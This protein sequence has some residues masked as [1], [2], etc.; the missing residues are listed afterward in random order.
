MELRVQGRTETREHFPKEKEPG[1]NLNEHQEFMSLQW[2]HGV[3]KEGNRC[4]GGR[5][6]S[7]SWNPGGAERRLLGGGREDQERQTDE[8]HRG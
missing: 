3:Q 5:H 7:C 1:R 6:I 2:N 4:V 8:A